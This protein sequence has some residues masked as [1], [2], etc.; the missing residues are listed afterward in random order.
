MFT[1]YTM[2]SGAGWLA[3]LFLL[4]ALAPA[5]A[6]AGKEVTID[7]VVQQAKVLGLDVSG[8]EGLDREGYGAVISEGV[9]NYCK[10][11]GQLADMDY[12]EQFRY[13]RFGLL[14]V[15]LGEQA[16]QPDF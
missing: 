2:R 4:I 9:R 10:A 8:L 15:I 1:A 12:A 6:F 16:I 5:T 3:A 13:Q 7:G 11:V 14:D